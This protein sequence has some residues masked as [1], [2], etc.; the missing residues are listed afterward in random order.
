MEF[1]PGTYLAFEIS[2]AS[3]KKLLEIFPPKFSKVICHHVTIEFNL[4]PEKLKKLEP[5]LR[6]RVMVIGKAEGEGIEAIAVSLDGN[7]RRVDGSFY[8]VT[9]SLNPPHKPVESN[10]L[11]RFIVRTLDDIVLSGEFKLLKK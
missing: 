11:E 1:I 4:T 10:N 9:L 6:S 3:R 8:H 7:R 5:L 2:E